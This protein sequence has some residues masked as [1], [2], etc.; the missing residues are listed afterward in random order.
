MEMLAGM[1]I[2]EEVRSGSSLSYTR[3]LLSLLRLRASI[4]TNL[5]FLD[6]ADDELILIGI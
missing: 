5:C 1:E 3:L 4:K 6:A 2:L